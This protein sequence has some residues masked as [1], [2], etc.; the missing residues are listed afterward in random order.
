VKIIVHLARWQAHRGVKAGEGVVR[1]SGVVITV[2]TIDEPTTIGIRSHQKLGIHW[3]F[4]NQ[5]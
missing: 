2:I 4:H 3:G 5:Q 1:D